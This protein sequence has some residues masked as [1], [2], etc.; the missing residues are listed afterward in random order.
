MEETMMK[1]RILVKAESTLI[2][3]HLR[4][5]SAQARL[6]VLAIGLLL[7]TVIM[8]NVALFEYFSTVHGA[9]IGALIVA[10]INA[11]LAI[12]AML[13][14]GRM[15]PG[16]EEDM[17]R[18]IREMALTELQADLDGVRSEFEQ[19]TG[20]LSKIRS[21]VNSALGLF[22]SGKSGMGAIGPAVSLVSALL[23]K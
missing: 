23:K 12:G 19:V 8:V 4:R 3:A 9:T 22:K 13:Y 15:R 10:G 20:E 18:D 14:A 1:L 2:R 21:N 7:L 11:V 6:Y 5:A 17:V 16:P